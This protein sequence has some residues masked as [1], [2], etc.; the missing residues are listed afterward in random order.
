MIFPG[1]YS[2]RGNFTPEF[3]SSN[4]RD[5]TLVYGTYDDERARRLE[6][7]RR[8]VLP[9]AQDGSPSPAHVVGKLR[10]RPYEMIPGG[11]AATVPSVSPGVPPT[12]ILTVHLSPNVLS[13]VDF[14]SKFESRH[15]SVS[16]V[17]PPPKRPEITAADLLLQLGRSGRSG[18]SGRPPPP[19]SPP[20]PEN[21]DGGSHRTRSHRSRRHP[22]VGKKVSLRHRRRLTK[23]RSRR[24]TRKR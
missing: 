13:F 23:A 11:A 8:G 12:P 17:I 4:Q 19:S 21:V 6:Y 10:V 14:V 24:N 3:M 18:R 1:D 7:D 2:V 22:R 9:W 15:R 5:N 20:G 16:P